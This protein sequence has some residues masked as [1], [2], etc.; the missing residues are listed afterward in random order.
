LQIAEQSRHEAT[1]DGIRITT[2]ECLTMA[3]C[4]DRPAAGEEIRDDGLLR[5]V[6]AVECGPHRFEKAYHW[7]AERHILPEPRRVFLQARPG[8]R[9]QATIRLASSKPVLVT[10]VSPGL[11]DLPLSLAHAGPSGNGYVVSFVVPEAVR[12]PV[13]QTYL[14]FATND[15]DEPVV[16]V[17]LYV[18]LRRETASVH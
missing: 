2:I 16:D 4:P 6:V 18:L 12:G 3:G 15:A 11:P 1:A 9:V 8:E 5:G 13:I 14:S 7:R 17:P 10:G